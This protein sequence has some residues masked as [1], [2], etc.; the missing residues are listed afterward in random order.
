MKKILI[1]LTLCCAVIAC[2]KN[3]VSF[4]YSPQNP[5]AGQPV[6]FSNLSSTGEEWE[7]TFGDG[8]TSTLKSPSHTFKQPGEY[9]VILKV[10]Q[11]NRWTA[12]RKIVVLDTVPAF[13][14][15]DTAFYI[16][17]D[18]TFTAEVYNPYNYDVH[19]TWY[20]GDTVAAVDQAALKC[21]FTRPAES[22]K[23]KLV[24]VLNNDTTVIERN[25]QIRDDVA[26]SVV[27]RTPQA[28]YRQRIFGE[29]AEE[30][31]VDASAKLLLDAEQ[32]TLQVYNSDTF[33]LSEL[34]LIIPDLEGFHIAKR[35]F[36]YRTSTG[37]WVSNI[38]GTYAVLIDG[39]PCAAMTLDDKKDNRIYWAN[40]RGIWYMP[41]VGS[42]NNKF[43]TVPVLLNTISTVTKIAVDSDHQ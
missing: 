22:E 1:L 32:D 7:W 40:E 19:Y 2:K 43:V 35:K 41:F 38:G 25:Y 39:T 4:S 10:D 21:F 37:L 17:R 27:F 24:V 6:T 26:H 16:F 42:D 3:D 12:Y 5:R 28:D 11:K 29:R 9:A 18:Y 20:L 31:K 23:V 34:K 36:Y 14:A 33:R 13:T 15:S 8:A 30:C